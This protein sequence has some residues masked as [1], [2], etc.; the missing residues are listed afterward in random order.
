M[1]TTLPRFELFAPDAFDHPGGALAE[2][3][4]ALGSE[5]FAVLSYELASAVLRDTRFQNSALRLME[6]FGIADGPV[7][8][9]RARSI[10]MIEGAPHLRLRTP[11]ARFMSP[12][13]V[14][15]IR[16]VLRD[17][18][19]GI[20]A[21]LDDS[22]PVDFHEGID[23][24]IPSLV[25]CHLAGAPATD[26][27]K[28]QSLS[29][30]TLSLLSRDRS[31]VPSILEAYDELFAYLADLIARK[32]E[33]GLGDDMLSYL[34]SLRDEGR[35]TEQELLA[36]AASMLEASSINTAHQSGL[37][38]WTLLGD[39][40]V[41]QRLL[42]DPSLIPAA[43]LEALRLYPRTGVVSKIATEDI[44]LAGTTIA[45][46]SDVH[47]AVWSANR[48]PKRFENPGAFD[49]ARERN[50]PLTFS[51]G[52]HNCLGQG[53]AKVEMEEVVKHLVDNYPDAVVVED[54]TRIG[55]VAGRWLVESLTV[56]LKP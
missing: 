11:L 27:P 53:L 4:L 28:V 10:I 33:Q 13:T 44:E 19:A 34:I 36:E 2:G 1:T 9:F 20:A 45:R 12:V 35:L 38:V 39:R 21:D 5:G 47:V 8:D 40:D 14:E 29:E 3:P 17:I 54:G 52:P 25:Y 16:G 22:A 43:V 23:R 31:L 56:N 24:R 37:V 6:D 26:A 42:E 30:R 41:W 15:K 49:L 7:H 46:G 51:T 18:V 55:Q 48:D 32:R 50:Q